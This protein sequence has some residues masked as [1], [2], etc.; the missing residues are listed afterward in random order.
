[1][2]RYTR[3]RLIGGLLAGTLL[4][5]AAVSA[6]AAQTDAGQ[7]IG[8]TATVSYKVGTVTQT[9]IESSPTGNSTPGAGNGTSTDFK[10]DA[11]LALTVVTGDTQLVST[12]PGATQQATKFTVSNIGNQNQSA[13]LTA[14][15]ETSHTDP[16]GNETGNAGFDATTP[17]VYADTNSNGT[18]DP[19]TDTV[20]TNIASLTKNG[21]SAVVF[22]VSSIPATATDGQFAVVGLKAQVGTENGSAI[23]T[24][25][26]AATWTPGTVQNIF[27]EAASANP[28]TGDTGANDGIASDLSGYKVSAASLTITKTSSVVSDPT[29]AATPH[30]IPGAVVRYTITVANAAGA[31]S[32]ATGISVVDNIGAEI[33]A[34]HVAYNTGS[35]KVSSPA[36]GN[37][38]TACTDTA[39][40]DSCSFATNTVT[41]D[42][43][44]LNGGESAVVTF[45]VTIQ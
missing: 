7:T 2:K 19:G 3:N 33:T 43:I 45:D 31:T 30:A 14:T 41:V 15:S 21:G 20:V 13:W 36:N 23:A 34:G 22:V 1:M 25:D 11:K 18:F 40:T 6:N 35:I 17:T 24:D 37:T 10:V 27:A 38:P 9:P 32:A 26:S 16:F 29:G 5:F 28:A 39:D 44:S 4:A 42:S 12:S 8:N